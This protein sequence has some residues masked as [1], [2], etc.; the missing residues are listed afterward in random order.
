MNTNVYPSTVHDWMEAIRRPVPY[1][2]GN[3]RLHIKTRSVAYTALFISA[4]LVLVLFFLPKQYIERNCFSKSSAYDSTYPF[5]EP[6]KTEYGTT[7]RIAVVTDLDT[8]SKSKKDK[9][10]WLSY[11]L[12]GNL[13]ISSTQKTVDV[14]FS[15]NPTL[16][17]S[18][19]SQ[20]G[21]GMELSE[22][23]VFNGKLY[24][25]DDRTGVIYEISRGKVYPWVLLTDGDGR[26][27]KG[28]L[29]YAGC[30]RI[31]KKGP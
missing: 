14:K 13:T 30:S 4:I 11:L 15:K 9:N 31:S 24:T 1:R 12:Y 28:T 19:L 18:T 6:F 27:S 3:A 8:D 10:T 2:V 22:L 5:T 26:T 7:Y 29:P 25:V 21:R 16:L 20:G 17:E 23:V